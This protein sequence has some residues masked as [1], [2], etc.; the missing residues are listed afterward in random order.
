MQ[1]LSPT[2]IMV[3]LGSLLKP[4][5]SGMLKCFLGLKLLEN[6]VFKKQVLKWCGRKP[7]TQA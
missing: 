5:V 7:V 6:L 3:S 2:C 1:N 4:C